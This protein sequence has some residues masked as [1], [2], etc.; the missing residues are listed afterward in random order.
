MS[1]LSTPPPRL[2]ASLP[3]LSPSLLSPPHPHT[4][5]P[6]RRR[7]AEDH[8][9]V[10]L[11]REQQHSVGG[12]DLH[13][14]Q[15]GA[16]SGREPRPHLY[17]RGGEKKKIQNICMILVAVL[18][19]THRLKKKRKINVKDVG[20]AR[21]LAGDFAFPLSHYQS[22]SYP[23][24][25]HPLYKRSFQVAF[26]ARWWRQADDVMRGRIRRAVARGRLEFING[27]WSQHDEATTHWVGMLDQV[28]LGESAAKQR[29]FNL[30]HTVFFS[31]ARPLSALEPLQKSPHDEPLTHLPCS[32]SGHR[33]L[34]KTLGAP[35]PTHT[36]TSYKS[37]H[38][39][40]SCDKLVCST[41]AT[42]S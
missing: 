21:L 35:P 20:R 8:R 32:H 5:A 4:N 28:T 2:P 36:H 37:Q 17:L 38:K 3:T 13:P 10:F 6:R 14:R 7:L 30:S 26:F 11:R 41:Q 39:T 24:M 12:S 23:A 29:S 19:P 22:N 34:N 31:L 16:L 42:V 15:R 18:S 25:L 27:G 9:P 33:F 40:L 1:F